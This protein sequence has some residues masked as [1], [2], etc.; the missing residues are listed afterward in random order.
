MPA[1]AISRGVHRGIDM[2]GDDF[3]F[4]TSRVPVG[5]RARVPSSVV[6]IRP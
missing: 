6:M 4:G 3:V 2:Y 1:G 5:D